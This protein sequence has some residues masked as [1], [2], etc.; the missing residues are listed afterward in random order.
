MTSKLQVTIPKAIA[1]LYGI[2]PGS[3]VAF[4]PAGDVVRMRRVDRRRRAKPSNEGRLRAFVAATERQ[5]TRDAAHPRATE[6]ERGWS[7]DELYDRDVSR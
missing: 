1:D 4:E 2:E 3:E 6:R 7:R 5:K